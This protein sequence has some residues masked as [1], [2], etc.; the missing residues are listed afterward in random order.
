MSRYKAPAVNRIKALSLLFILLEDKRE[1]VTLTKGK[2]S[3]NTRR[4]KE[5][6]YRG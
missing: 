4:S 6:L 3:R 1:Q 2:E 5:K